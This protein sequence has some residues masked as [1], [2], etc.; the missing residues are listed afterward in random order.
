M[1]FEFIKRITRAVLQLGTAREA[2]ARGGILN[3]KSKDLF[4]I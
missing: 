1:V 4:K 3:I 2:E